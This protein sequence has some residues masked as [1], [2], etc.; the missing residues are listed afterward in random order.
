MTPVREGVPCSSCEDRILL[1]IERLEMLRDQYHI[2]QAPPC[3]AAWDGMAGDDTRRFCTTCSKHVYNVAAL[4]SGDLRDLVTVT[5]G[6]FCARLEPQPHAK[7]EQ[8]PP[9]R[10]GLVKAAGLLV[11]GLLSFRDAVFGQKP[12]PK[13]GTLKGKVTDSAKAVVVTG[14]VTILNGR[15]DR[16]WRTTP[17]AKGEFEIKGLEP[18]FYSVQAQ[19]PGF[20]R[21]LR[22]RVSVSGGET[23]LLPVQLTLVNAG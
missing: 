17:D 13:T 7:N 16:R 12:D 2:Q 14:E 21:F 1:S 3:S 9:T 19:V 15:G 10:R 20:A 22:K 18:G 23:T 8:T 11:A 5:G 4:P 6:R